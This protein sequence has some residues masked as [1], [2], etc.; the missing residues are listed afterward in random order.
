MKTR[1]WGKTKSLKLYLKTETRKTTRARAIQPPTFKFALP[2][3]SLE[4]WKVGYYHPDDEVCYLQI[5]S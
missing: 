5:Q 2:V 3:S 1:I 4:Y